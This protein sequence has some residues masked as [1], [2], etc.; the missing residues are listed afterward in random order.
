MSSE[1]TITL[2]QHHNIIGIKEASGD[3]PQCMEI[4][5]QKSD[6]F[7]LISGDDS[8]TI[9]LISVGGVGVISV[10]ANGLAQPFYKAVHQALEGDFKAARETYFPIMKLNQL[11]FEEGNPSGIKAV[12]E[13]K[14][15]GNATVRLPLVKASEPLTEK[16][17]KQLGLI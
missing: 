16:L 11:L 1:T 7:L 6:D 17:K 13:L 4:A 8:I 15:L 2:S 5:A 14:K 3:I 12:C 10:I 9:P